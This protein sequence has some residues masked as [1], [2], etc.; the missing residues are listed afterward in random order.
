[1]PV[2]TQ[3]IIRFKMKYIKLVDRIKYRKPVE[4]KFGLELSKENIDRKIERI[5]F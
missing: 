3:T 4:V 1:M 5:E 2:N